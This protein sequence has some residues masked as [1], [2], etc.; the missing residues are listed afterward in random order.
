M[1]LDCGSIRRVRDSCRAVP[2]PIPVGLE[3]LQSY[4]D[5]WRGWPVLPLKRQHPIR[6]SFL[7][8]R[9]DR[10]RG[11][12]YHEGVDVAVRDDRPERGAPRGRTH[13]VYAVGGAACT[14]RPPVASA[15]SPASGISVKRVS[16]SLK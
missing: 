7:D 4:N 12:I 3:T 9:P 13:R 2:Q 5:A 8:P 6:G 14:R 1:G 10:R 11:A 15:A 16:R